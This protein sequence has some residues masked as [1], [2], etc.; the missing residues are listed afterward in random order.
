V[1]VDSSF[2]L[3]WKIAALEREEIEIERE[4]R[5]RCRGAPP[6]LREDGI[7]WKVRMGAERRTGRGKARR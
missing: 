3:R 7:E 2:A 1:D 6:Q 4:R 5:R